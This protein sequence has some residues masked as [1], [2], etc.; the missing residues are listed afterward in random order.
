M[1]QVYHTNHPIVNEDVKPWFK[2]VGDDAKSNSQLRLNAVEKRLA[3][4]N[5]IDDQLIKETLR[6]KDDKNNPVCRTNNR[7]S[8]VFTFASVVMTFSEKPYLQIAAGPP[9]ESEFKRFDFSAK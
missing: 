8:Y 2:A 3:S 7:N 9:D 5:D 1:E 6:S 4:A